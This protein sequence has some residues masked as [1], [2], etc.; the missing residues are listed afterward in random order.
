MQIKLAV[1]AAVAFAALSIATPTE[2][3][4][5]REAVHELVGRQGPPKGGPP[6]GGPPRGGPP[7]GGPPSGGPPKVTPPPKSQGPPKVTTTSKSSTTT[8]SKSSSKPSGTPPSRPRCRHGPVE[9]CQDVRKAG[10]KTA[11]NAL[12]RAHVRVRNPNTP[13]GLNCRALPNYGGRG[14]SIW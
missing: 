14:G 6:S 12:K 8:Q 5:A 4:A 11:S 10:S 3:I 9:C 7:S 1:I 2:P 13:I